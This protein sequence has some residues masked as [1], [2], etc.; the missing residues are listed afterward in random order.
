MFMNEEKNLL[1]RRHKLGRWLLVHMY[2]YVYTS[3]EVHMHIKIL[4]TIRLRGVC[5]H[6]KIVRKNYIYAYAW[7]HVYVFCIYIHTHTH[8]CNAYELNPAYISL[9]CLFLIVQYPNSFMCI[10]LISY[11]TTYLCVRLCSYLMPISKYQV[12]MYWFMFVY[13]Y[14]VCVVYWEQISQDEELHACLTLS[15]IISRGLILGSLIFKQWHGSE[16]YFQHSRNESLHKSRL[17]VLLHVV[18][19]LKGHDM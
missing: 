8:I 4:I 10:N 3:T 16:P 7:I 11:L 13:V 15:I 17:N 1:Y 19:D 5:R 12:L 14:I 2:M 18:V 9:V 6:T